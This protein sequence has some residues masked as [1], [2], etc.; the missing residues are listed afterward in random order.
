MKRTRIG[1]AYITALLCAFRLAP[2]AEEYQLL[3]PEQR[4]EITDAQTEIVIRTNVTD[5]AVYLNG[6]YQ[7]RTPLTVRGL[8]AGVYELAV[9]KEGY[10]RTGYLVAVERGQ[11]HSFYVP[12]E[13]ITGYLAIID[14][15]DESSYYVDDILHHTATMEL[16]A[17]Y[18]TVTVKKFGYTDETRAVYI[19]PQT[20]ITISMPLSRA[21]FSLANFTVSRARFNPALSGSL[22]ECA[23]SFSV[24]APE[25]GT[26]TITDTAGTVVYHTAL[27]LFTTWQQKIIWNGRDI[28]GKELPD[29]RYRATLTAGGITAAAETVIDRSLKIVHGDYPP[30]GTGIGPIATAALLPA[31]T[32]F[33]AVQAT[34]LFDTAPRPFSGM[35]IS[36]S[37]GYTPLSWLELSAQFTVY[38]GQAQPPAA[39]T[40][41]AQ[42]GGKIA[43]GNDWWFRGSG[44][45]RWGMFTQNAPPPAPYGTDTGTGLS[46]GGAISF[47]N[48]FF[49]TGIT[50]E[51]T[52]GAATGKVT[53]RDSVWRNGI[54][55]QFTP[56]HT[57]SIQTWLIL[58]SAFHI[59]DATTNSASDLIYW[60]RA[61]DIGISTT[62]SI[63]NTPFFFHAGFRT[64]LFFNERTR[65][66]TSIGISYVF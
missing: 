60:A 17:G 64:L 49:S 30:G 22:G 25:T 13:I 63:R 7:G 5:A 53:I 46:G 39:G 48:T 56:V 65:F 40:V 61:L 34:A 57:V 27:L 20:L 16:A 6:A 19:V 9:E 47:A 44:F 12:L 4:Q 35:P 54:T 52:Y 36:F 41:A 1:F 66:G 24:T 3:P 23:F 45:L 26:L 31:R 18:H 14:T 62:V 55:V 11:R 2:Y 10:G 32:F 29:G 42:F 33:L 59:Y 8:V 50:S 43:I 37:F 38:T 58:N 28:Q 21:S 51:Y 15:P